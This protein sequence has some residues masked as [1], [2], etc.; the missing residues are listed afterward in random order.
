MNRYFMI[1]RLTGPL[2]LLLLGVVALLHQM[3]MVH[4]GIFVP[5]LLI[6]LGVMK[7]LERAVLETDGPWQ[8]PAGQGPTIDAMNSGV[9]AA[10]GSAST[11]ESA[12]HEHEGGQL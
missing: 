4:W 2:I 9:N 6:L 3:H 8:Q 11:S 7:L 1:H 10:S 5:L 12:F